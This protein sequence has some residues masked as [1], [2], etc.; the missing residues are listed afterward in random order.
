MELISGLANYSSTMLAITVKIGKCEDWGL[1]ESD[2]HYAPN[3][4]ATCQYFP[5]TIQH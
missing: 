1:S 3:S 4:V 2:Y 5:S